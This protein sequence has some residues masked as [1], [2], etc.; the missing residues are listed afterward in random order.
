MQFDIEVFVFIETAF[1]RNFKEFLL[2]SSISYFAIKLV[3]LE[4]VGLFL[5][6]FSNSC[7]LKVYFI[8]FS[9]I[10]SNFLP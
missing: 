7:I 10:F 5:T 1:L 3:C 8:T 2:Q 6:V 4:F 9:V